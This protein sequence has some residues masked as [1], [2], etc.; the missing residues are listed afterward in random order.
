VELE[1][2]ARAAGVPAKTL[3]RIER[4]AER[5][6]LPTLQRLAHLLG[7]DPDALLDGRAQTS[8]LAAAFRKQDAL[9]PETIFVIADARAAAR[10]LVSLRGAQW[11]RDRRDQLA[12][13]R[14]AVPRAAAATRAEEGL[15]AA[16]AMRKQFGLG[17]APVDSVRAWLEDHGVLVMQ[18]AVK[19]RD[20]FGVALYEGDIGPVILLNVTASNRSELPTAR[21]MTAFHELHHLLS[22]V[23]VETRKP[24]GVLDREGTS[25][26][27]ESRANAFAIHFLAPEGAVRRMLLSFGIGNGTPTPAHA[28]EALCL[29]FGVGLDAMATHLERNL[30][31]QDVARTAPDSV[32]RATIARFESRESLPEELDPTYIDIPLHRRGALLRSTREAFQAGRLSLGDVR[33]LLGVPA[34]RDL[35]TLLRAGGR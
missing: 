28:L 21:R 32:R 6:S 20:F 26:P 30:G 19:D 27:R 8:S 15:R 22:D 9:R 17:E 2:L 1:D 13:L 5:P 24:F 3:E 14:N 25:G 12:K 18:V 16:V 34:G 29:N 35:G 31:F 7:A 4:D 33:A 11:L 10:D 23:D